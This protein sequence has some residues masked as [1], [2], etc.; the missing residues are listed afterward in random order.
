MAANPDVANVRLAELVAALS[1]GIDLGF[2]QPMEH[3]LRQCLIALRLAERVGADEETRAV[4]YYTGL[5]VNVGCHTDAHEQAKWFGDDIALKADQVGLRADQRARQDDGPAAAGRGPTAAAPPARRARVRD[6]RVPRAE[7]HVL[8]PRRDGGRPG[9]GARA[10]GGSEARPARARTSRGTGAGGRTGS[11]GDEIPLAARIVQLAE[12]AEV[13]H[14]MR[15][16]DGAISLARQRSGK[17]FD[18]ALA[19]AAVRGGAGDL[20]RA[21]LG[22]PLGRRDRRRAGA[23]RRRS[24]ASASTPRSRRSRTTSTSSRPTS[25]GH[26]RAVADLAAEAG[27]DLRTAGRRRPHAA[28]CGARPR[29]RPPR[30]VQHHLGQARPARRRRA[31]AR[32]AAPV[33]H[34]AHAAR[35][36]AARAVRRDRG[37]ALR[38]ARRLRLSAR[39]VGRRDLAAGAHPGRG[40]RLPGDARAAAAQARAPAGATRPPSCAPRSGPAASTPRPPTRCSAPS[41]IASRAGARGLRG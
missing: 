13:A 11:Q 20:R 34:A 25:L 14:R 36:E 21:R 16:V 6:L 15:G 22:R 8:P 24:P 38:A 4:V 39:R 28:P 27:I 7:R 40:R 23:R 17:Q 1:L 18:P 12:Y 9:R 35:V 2:G 5:L 31:R 10:A 37:A 33:L 30:R 32:L 26:S 29:L 3:V 19:A 41:A